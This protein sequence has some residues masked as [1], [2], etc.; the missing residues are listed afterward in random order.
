MRP[1]RPSLSRPRLAVVL[2]ALVL[3]GAGFFMIASPSRSLPEGIT[4]G[5]WVNPTLNEACGH[6]EIC[7]DWCNRD[8]EGFLQPAGVT[9][10]VDVEDYYDRTDDFGACKTM[11][12]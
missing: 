3:A 10:C 12:P 11:R 1:F 4:G 8:S 2:T 9:C 6:G 5:I 7:V